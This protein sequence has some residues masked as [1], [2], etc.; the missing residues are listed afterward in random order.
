M[1][2]RL[3]ASIVL[4]NHNFNDV[5][6]LI[7]SISKSCVDKLYII[8]NSKYN[9]IESFLKSD[10][11]YIHNPS[12]PG[13][14]SSH[15]LAISNSL[16]FNYDYHCII[17]PDIYFEDGTIEKMKSFMILNQDVGL[18]MPKILNNDGTL[19]YLPKLLPLPWHV[20]LRKLK[21]PKFLYN[22][23]IIKIELRN[24]LLDKIINVPILSGCFLMS[25][26]KILNEMGSFDE[27]YFMYF[28][29]WDLSRRIHLK[30]RTLYFPNSFVYHGYNSGANKN[31][32]LFSIFLKSGF[33]YFTKWGWLFDKERKSI[34]INTL[35][36]LID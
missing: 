16:K 15:N 31:F 9:N 5:K 22:K 1:K 7:E 23:H 14:G 25:N 36:S 17:N 20:L 6:L 26:L 30:Y 28:E 11:T 24:Y 21:F 27:N 8:D 4:Y 32:K 2:I 3:S 13:F 35:N 12:N 33:Y 29:D 19:Q 34:N 10:I 18:M